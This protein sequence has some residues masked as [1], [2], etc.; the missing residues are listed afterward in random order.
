LRRGIGV[1]GVS[2][3]LVRAIFEARDRRHNET[4]AALLELYQVLVTE[5]IDQ[6]AVRPA[7][8]AERLS[9]SQSRIS[10]EPHG[11]AAREVV[12]HV[13]NWL[14]S[15]EPRLQLPHPPSWSMPQLA[16]IIAEGEE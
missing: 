7:V 16:T 9:I 11:D 1:S 8:L 12:S 5:L 4:H 14:L 2:R 13:V 15:L 3:D 10:Q 6:G